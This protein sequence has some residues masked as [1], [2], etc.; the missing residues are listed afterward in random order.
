MRSATAVRVALAALQ[1]ARDQ[2]DKRAINKWKGICTGL[3][4]GASIHR[5]HRWS[6]HLVV[7]R[8]LD[9]LSTRS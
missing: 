1:R 5:M 3:A 2:G 4:Y 6:R 8:S 7:M 9:D